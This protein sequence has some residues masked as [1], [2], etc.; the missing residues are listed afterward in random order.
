MILIS[1]AV[2][3]ILMISI[4]NRLSLKYIKYDDNVYL[5]ILVNGSEVAAIP[6]KG[7]YSV[8]ISCTNADGKWDYESWEFE[9]I[10][11]NGIAK[12]SLGFVSVI[13][14]DMVS[15]IK[16]L[17]KGS[18]DGTQNVS[19]AVGVWQEPVGDWRYEGKNPD[20]YLW[21]NNE[22]WRIIG[23][24]SDNS[25]GKT[26][27]E[28]VKI[29]RDNSI[30]S[31]TWQKNDVNNWEHATSSLK[32]LL[33]NFYY[34]GT[35][36][37][38]ITHCYSSGTTTTG[39]CNFIK[40][41]ITNTVYRNMIENVTWKLGAIAAMNTSKTVYD[42]ERGTEVTWSYPT[43]G[44]GYIGLMYPSDYGY[45]VLSS[46]CE[47]STSLVSYSNAACGGQSWLTGSASEW[48]IMPSISDSKKV[49]QVNSSGNASAF[50]GASVGRLVRPVLYLKSDV[51]ILSG[52]GSVE[53]PYIIVP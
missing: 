22:L 51:K 41:G 10:N 33:N 31:L 28:L 18:G 37:S 39:N 3:F 15:H 46:S 8:S 25:H 21:F 7:N 27:K 26:G 35:N 45:S 38:T 2:I 9:I 19:N 49:W 16:G 32:M 6:A 14:Y 17:S 30:G 5:A 34:N 29:I 24:F 53:T 40:N 36:E 48:T 20:N 47:R 43:S 11:I 23:V 44:T 42:A 52:N 50:N 12:C 1:I 4:S 13:P